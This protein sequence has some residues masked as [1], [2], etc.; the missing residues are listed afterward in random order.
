MSSRQPGVRA[1]SDV[2]KPFL[3]SDLAVK[4]AKSENKNGFTTS[5][6]AMISSRINKFYW[7][8]RRG[9]GAAGGMATSYEST[10]KRPQSHLAQ[11]T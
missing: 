8:G 4:A 10:Q 3:F 7:Y 6:K 5:E 11:S 9:R 1:F 2:K